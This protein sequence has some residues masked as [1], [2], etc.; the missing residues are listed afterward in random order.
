MK[1]FNQMSFVWIQSDWKW[2][3]DLG[4]IWG[5]KYIF[6]KKKRGYKNPSYKKLKFYGA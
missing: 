1:A 2:K 4:L 6:F 3:N 5:K